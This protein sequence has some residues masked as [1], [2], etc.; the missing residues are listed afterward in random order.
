M[1]N[2]H[3]IR[4]KYGKGF[5]VIVSPNTYQLVSKTFSKQKGME[6]KLSPEE[7]EMNR[8]PSPEL[9]AHIMGKDQPLLLP[10][11]GR[12]LHNHK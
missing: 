2:G 7:L 4:I 10:G 9:Q 12:G 11:V 8:N 3:K 1:R 6:L 5:N